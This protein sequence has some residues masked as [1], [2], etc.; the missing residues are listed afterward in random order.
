MYA[1]AVAH[2][3]IDLKRLVIDVE[4]SRNLQAVAALCLTALAV[5]AP[6]GVCVSGGG[7]GLTQLLEPAGEGREWV[8]ITLLVVNV[9]SPLRHDVLLREFR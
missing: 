2:L 7:A 5:D 3:A 6:D 9:R 4:R 1:L 8:P